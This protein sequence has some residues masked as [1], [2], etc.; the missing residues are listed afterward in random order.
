MKNKI[1]TA[2]LLATHA[3]SAQ[4]L[5]DG[6]IDSTFGTNGLAVLSAATENIEARVAHVGTD[7]KFYTASTL[8]TGSGRD[9]LLARFNANGTPDNSFGFNGRAYF[10]PLLGGSDYVLDMKLGANNTIVIVGRSYTNNGQY[11]IARF[12]SNGELDTTFNQNGVV[13][14][15][16]ISEDAWWGCTIEPNGSIT[17]VGVLSGGDGNDKVITRYL[18]NGNL[19]VNFGFNGMNVLDESADEQFTQIYRQNSTR[20]YVVGETNGV[21]KLYAY[22]GSGN[23]SNA[24]G[25]AGKFSFNQ[26]TGYR[27]YVHD[28]ALLGNDV[29][30]AGYARNMQTNK[31]DVLVC[32]M[33]NNGVLDNAFGTNGY[34]RA[35]L[36]S[37]RNDIATEIK[38]LAD[39]SVFLA[40]E[41]E[42]A[43]G[44]YTPASYLL[45]SDGSLWSSY[46]T[47]GLMHY[48]LANSESAHVMHMAEDAQGKLT[49]FC[50]SSAIGGKVEGVLVG[51]KT[52]I[53]GIGLEELA[54]F[55]DLVAYPNPATDNL[56]ARFTSAAAGTHNFVLL[57]VSGKITSTESFSISAG[58]NIVDLSGLLRNTR[59]GVY[60]LQI[61][62]MG[63]LIASFKIMRN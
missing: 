21:E 62:S 32:K 30:V 58:E 31:T 15:G 42:D 9:V 4:I 46:G 2:L 25:T 6:R 48:S 54:P 47:N 41:T 59:Q 49:L 14:G 34:Y 40:G 5:I 12:L 24:F 29:Y 39:G 10:D 3:L 11:Y 1:F 43:N 44:D 13:S 8:G 22:D 63:A 51:L 26:L 52:S 16:N 27:V 50:W 61:E 36:G 57:D 56:F 37:G 7:G 23:L 60:I 53:S 38:I 18:S 33:N 45:A 20:F 28:V 17:T 35:D 19:D 55:A